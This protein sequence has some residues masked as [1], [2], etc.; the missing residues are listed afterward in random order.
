M[1]ID[2][3]K[4]LV[5]RVIWI[6]VIVAIALHPQMIVEL[7]ISIIPDGYQ[8]NPGGQWLHLLTGNAD[9]LAIVLAIIG[10]A[11][12][13]GALPAKIYSIMFPVKSAAELMVEEAINEAKRLH[14]ELPDHLK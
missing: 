6:G 9:P 1:K 2:I 11:V 14:E 8:F 3:D 13:L 10:L 7:F 5:F 12:L 4:R